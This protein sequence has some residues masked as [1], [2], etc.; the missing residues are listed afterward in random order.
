[1]S[2]PRTFRFGVIAKNPRSGTEFAE[3]E[4]PA[5]RDDLKP[6]QPVGRVD[7]QALIAENSS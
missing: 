7:L 3:L 5:I 2:H 4:W 1:M 6:L